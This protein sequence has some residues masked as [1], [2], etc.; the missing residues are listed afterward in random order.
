MMFIMNSKV[1]Q[2]DFLEN[3]PDDAILDAQYVVI[4]TRIRKSSNRFDNIVLAHNDLFPNSSSM[5][6][7]DEESK[8]EAY[9]EQLDEKRALLAI[10]VMGCIE[11]DYNIIFICAKNEDKLHYLQYLSE[12]IYLTF[13]YPVYEYRKYSKGKIGLLKYKKKEVLKECKKYCK[14]AS[15]KSRREKMKTERGRQELKK[16]FKSFSKKKMK[17]ELEKQDLYI[18]GMSRKE[19]VEVYELFVLN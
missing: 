7:L 17:K 15:L 19:M 14:E 6:K 2:N 11:K 8:R 1:F 4:S 18:D 3:E 13:G 5:L 16:E 12:Y 10:L 9:F